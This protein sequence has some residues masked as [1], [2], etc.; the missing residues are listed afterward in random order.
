MTQFTE[1]HLIDATIGPDM[2]V[3]PLTPD[4]GFSLKQFRA[5]KERVIQS[6]LTGKNILTVMPAGFGKSYCQAAEAL[7]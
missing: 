5:G 7:S 1:L 4:R 3:L 6:V 2:S